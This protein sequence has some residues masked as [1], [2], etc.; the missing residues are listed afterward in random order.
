MSEEKITATTV[1]NQITTTLGELHIATGTESVLIT[2]DYESQKATVH[3]WFDRDPISELQMLAITADHV[4]LDKKLPPEVVNAFL[5]S[6]E[7]TC[8]R[9]MSVCTAE[10]LHQVPS[11]AKEQKSK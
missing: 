9:Y 4:I 7:Q 6:I 2:K 1:L 8:S 11:T 5:Q 3:D 10:N